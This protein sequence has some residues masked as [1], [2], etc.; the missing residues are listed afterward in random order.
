MRAW[1]KQIDEQDVDVTTQGISDFLGRLAYM[2]LSVLVGGRDDFE[3]GHQTMAADV[4]NGHRSPTPD[5][6]VSDRD[7]TCRLQLKD[8]TEY[9][10]TDKL[11]KVER[12]GRLLQAAVA[13][14]LLDAGDSNSLAQLLR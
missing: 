2:E 5:L 6:G 1:G 8:G 11:E 7:R 12:F 3:Q 14:I 10:F 13:G 4:T 9:V